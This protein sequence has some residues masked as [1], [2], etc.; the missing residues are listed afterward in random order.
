MKLPDTLRLENRRVTD[1]GTVQYDMVLTRHGRL[2]LTAQSL[3]RVLTG[4][5]K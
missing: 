2:Y 1:H 3:W 5:G 4:R